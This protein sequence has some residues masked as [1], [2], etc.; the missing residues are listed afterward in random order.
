MAT[1]PAY[2]KLLFNGFGE[3]PD[4]AIKRSENESGPAKQLKTKS[5]VLV[6]RPVSY[7]LTSAADYASF[8]T[9]FKVTINFGADWFDWTDPVDGATKPARISGGN[10]ELKP[11][12]KMLDRWVAEFQIETWSA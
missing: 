10:I 3:K 4:N 5:R 9:W 7:L 6:K 2:P 11:Q 1:F 12:R 8:N